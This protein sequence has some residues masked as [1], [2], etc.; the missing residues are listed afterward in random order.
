MLES[1]KKTYVDNRSCSPKTTYLAKQIVH[2]KSD[3]FPQVGIYCHDF[4][5][6]IFETSHRS[7][8]PEVIG[9]IVSPLPVYGTHNVKVYT[10]YLL[11][12]V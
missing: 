9:E 7:L 1:N 8:V 12:P 5:S 4:L 10:R 6:D 3:I 11:Q 2:E